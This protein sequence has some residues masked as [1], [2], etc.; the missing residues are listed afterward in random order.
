MCV[1]SRS[2]VRHLLSTFIM[3]IF[4]LILFPSV[5]LFGDYLFPCVLLFGDY[6]VQFSNQASFDILLPW[7]NKLR[8]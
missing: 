8:Y 3:S 7:V 5:L 6:F 1:I 4:L 2:V